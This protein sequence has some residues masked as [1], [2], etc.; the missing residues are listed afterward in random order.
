MFFC[1]NFFIFIPKTRGLFFD[2]HFCGKHFLVD[3]DFVKVI[4]SGQLA[5][6]QLIGINAGSRFIVANYLDQ[7]S[8]G[9]VQANVQ[10]GS[11]GEGIV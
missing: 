6:I 2:Y 7:F 11:F 9:A 1:P 5:A 10:L 4:S 8:I 3:G